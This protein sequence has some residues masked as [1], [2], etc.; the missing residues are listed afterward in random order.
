MSEI[1]MMRAE[2]SHLP[3]FDDPVMSSQRIFRM[4]LDAMS[5]PGKVINSEVPLEAPTP[6]LATSA[7][8]CLTVLDRETPLWLDAKA[9]QPQ[10]REYLRFHCGC[11]LADRAKNAQFA[12]I[13]DAQ[14]VPPL[15]QFELGTDEEAERSA[16]LIIQVEALS[17]EGELKLTGPGIEA[18]RRLHIAPLFPSFL[19]QVVLNQSLFPRGLD[20]VFASSS[21]VVAIPRSTKIEVQ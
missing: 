4:L 21:Q 1:R 7:G 18:A 3:A 2:I 16:T 12:L 6:L 17:S 14:S 10:V 5:S 8:I 15:E 20:F 13:A 11:R 19:Q 9:D